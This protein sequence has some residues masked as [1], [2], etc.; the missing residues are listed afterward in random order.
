[1]RSAQHE[2]IELLNFYK[3]RGR[4]DAH[5]LDGPRYD[6]PLNPV[7]E[8]AYNEE[9]EKTIKEIVENERN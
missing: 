1:M 5:E 3:N 2:K 7:Y 4:N 9:F 8:N 6:G